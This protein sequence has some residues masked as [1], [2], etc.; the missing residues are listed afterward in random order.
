M[1][2]F[3]PVTESLECFLFIGSTDYKPQNFYIFTPTTKRNYSEL[4][5]AVK[6]EKGHGNQI[7]SIP[8]R[9]CIVII[10]NFYIP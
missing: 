5:T 3:S 9:K 10:E 2:M 7:L 1:G 4:L 6:S 8:S